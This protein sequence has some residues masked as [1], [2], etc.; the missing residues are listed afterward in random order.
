[1]GAP[2]SAKGEELH[3]CK[4]HGDVTSKWVNFTQKIGKVWSHF[5]PP[6]KE[7][8]N[9]GQ[10][11]RKFGLNHGKSLENGYK[12]EQKLGKLLQQKNK[13]WTKFP[14]QK[15]STENV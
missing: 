5:D 6:P 10:M 3:I 15:F 9:M 12:S 2:T 14:G 1:M 7:S 4:I 13:A 11:G 8:R